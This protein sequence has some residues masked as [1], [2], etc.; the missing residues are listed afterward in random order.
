[1]LIDVTPALIQRLRDRRVFFEIDES[2]FRLAGMGQL[3]WPEGTAVEP[4]C[5]ILSGNIVSTIGSFSY[6]WSEMIP[7]VRIGRYCSIAVGLTVPRP[8]HWFTGVSSSSFASDLGFSIMRSAIRDSGTSYARSYPNPQKP[9]PVIEHDVWIGEFATLM[10]GIVVGTGAVV[11]AHAVVTRDV[12]PYAIV[13]GNPARIIRYRF[14]AETVRK[15]LR[16]RWW[17]YRFADFGGLDLADP[18]AFCDHLREAGLTRFTP[19]IISA[20]DLS[21]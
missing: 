9:M 19:Q 12:P 5:G 10:P 11:A 8:R 7:G 17:E 1:M 21:D 2:Q 6:S 3:V 4:Y 15:L 20:A 16:S 13:G 14:A 18:E